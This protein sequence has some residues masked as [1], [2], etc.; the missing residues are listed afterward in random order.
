MQY[1]NFN[2]LNKFKKLIKSF[3]HIIIINFFEIN[4][5]IFNIFDLIKLK[6]QK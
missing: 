5:K 4:F 3:I 2:I 6:Q 1:K